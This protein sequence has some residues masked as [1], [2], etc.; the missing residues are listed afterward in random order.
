MR[1]R[2]PNSGIYT[3]NI[4]L[5]FP[6]EQKEELSR[7]CKQFNI[8]E[9]DI[10]RIIIEL[11]INEPD[12]YIKKIK[13]VSCR[14]RVTKE[15]EKKFREMFEQHEIYSLKIDIDNLIKKYMEKGN[16]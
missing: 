16:E 14:V 10:L 15:V 12:K 13:N 1:G 8:L 3:Q 4:N 11:I 6:I 2:K 7:L 5:N 9:S